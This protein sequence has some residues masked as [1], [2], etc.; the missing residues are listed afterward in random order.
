MSTS[1][2]AKRN[3]FP[4]E[5]RGIWHMFF[6]CHIWAASLWRLPY[7]NA[8]RCVSETLS[9][10]LP[11]S[12]LPASKA[13]RCRLSLG[14]DHN[15]QLPW[16]WQ[17]TIYAEVLVPITTFPITSTPC[18]VQRCQQLDWSMSANEGQEAYSQW[19]IW[20]KVKQMNQ[21]KCGKAPFMWTPL[22]HCIYELDAMN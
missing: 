15:K 9:F 2:P 14:V 5:L 3:E 1:T 11:P 22:I 4:K 7:G 20:T 18:R 8:N 13:C 12:T 10:D 17:K 6:L 19:L 16:K 21:W